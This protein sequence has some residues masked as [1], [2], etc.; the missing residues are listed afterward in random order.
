VAYIDLCSVKWPWQ[1]GSLAQ[2]GVHRHSDQAFIMLEKKLFT[3]TRQS[4]ETQLL[5]GKW[6]RDHW[7]W[8]Y[9]QGRVDAIIFMALAS[10]DLW[11][12]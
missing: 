5:S 1:Q 10:E 11:D 6:H 9:Q 12:P 8:A 7:V 4:G 2:E 3:D